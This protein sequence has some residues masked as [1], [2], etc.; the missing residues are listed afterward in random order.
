MPRAGRDL[1]HKT[2]E[3][4]NVPVSVRTFSFF[5]LVLHRNAISVSGGTGPTHLHPR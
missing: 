3:D 1:I 2:L 4:E 5:W